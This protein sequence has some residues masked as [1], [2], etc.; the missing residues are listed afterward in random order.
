MRRRIVLA[1]LVLGMGVGAISA[2]AQAP[3]GSV[4]IRLL[5]VPK[6]LANDPR[7]RLYIID[8][9]SPGTTLSRRIEVSNGTNRTLKIQL[10]AAAASVQGG[11]FQFA[12]GRKQND[13][14]SWTS[15][16]PISVLIPAGGN[17][18]AT[19]RIAVPS[20]ATAGERYAV[21][22]AQLP[23]SG[24]SGGVTAVNR[25]GIRIYLSVGPGGD[26]PSDFVIV[27][28]RAL[29]TTKGQPEVAASVRNTGQ[30]ALDMSGE[31]RLTD[32]P[33]GLTA[34]PYP[35]QLGTT[36]GIGQTE[37]VHVFLDPRIPAGP[38]NAHLT[39]HSGLLT[40][41]AK[42]TI[43][44]PATFGAQGSAVPAVPDR[45]RQILLPIGGGLLLLLLIAFGLFF[46][47]KRRRDEEDEKTTAA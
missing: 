4:G 38:W 46:I 44:F 12:D 39:L 9:V 47:Y 10:Y 40:R 17:A 23:A 6:N 11:E 22:W 26:P 33:G 45:G 16:V 43:T 7:A 18:D 29:R 42:A 32:G 13:V 24:S 28:L 14:S 1:G 2:F 20:N 25:V 21:V 36:L 15:V 41:S 27:S 30:R 37:E 8:H 3:S 5:E 19:V 34:G 31:L 35:A